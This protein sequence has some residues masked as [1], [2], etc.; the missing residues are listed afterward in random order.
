MTITCYMCGSLGKTKEHVP[1]KCIFPAIK[2]T[3]GKNFRKN[4]ITVSS[5]ERHNS[6]KSK[7]DLYFFYCLSM[8]VLSN[9]EA[10]NQFM[11]KIKRDI[12][13]NNELINRILKDNKAVKIENTETG[14]I[15]NTI[16]LKL[17]NERIL[18]QLDSI[19]RAIHFHH[20]KE[21]WLGK[22]NIFNNFLLSDDV[23]INN[24]VTKM[25]S[26]LDDLFTNIEFHGENKEIFK[27]QVYE[28]ISFVTK[29][30]IVLCIRQIY[31]LLN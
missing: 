23:E 11:T 15:E 14:N 22:V 9:S 18:N 28:K 7:D 24:S 31:L 25:D 26:M 12:T 17:E 21:K 27:Y 5:C 8:N 1:P 19:S 29:I 30:V 3:N 16:A 20:Y 13:R 10:Q 6:E 4:L 2:Y